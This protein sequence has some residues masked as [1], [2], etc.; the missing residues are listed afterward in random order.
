MLRIM[1]RAVARS[2]MML[3][4]VPPSRTIPWTRA[5]WGSCWRHSPIAWKRR[6]TRVEGVLA[7]PRLAGRVGGLAGERHVDVLAGQEHAAD[8]VA[9]AR[10]EEERRVEAVEEA[11]VEHELLAAPPLL[12]RRA[13]EDDLPG[14]LVAERRQGDRRAHARRRHRVVAAAVAEPRERVV[15]GEDA[16]PRPVGP[17]PPVSRP[18]TAVARRP[19]GCST[20]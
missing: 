19:A 15:L 17:R 5:C 12:R 9:V 14:E 13:E 18:R 8:H 1:N 20:V 6:T 7:L 3:A 11:V 2:G 4:A 10:V 16:D